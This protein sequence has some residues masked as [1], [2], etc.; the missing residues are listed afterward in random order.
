[1]LSEHRNVVEVT[2]MRET[3]VKVMITGVVWPSAEGYLLRMIFLW[4]DELIA[5]NVSKCIRRLV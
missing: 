2:D 4:F 3:L 5:Q 1:M